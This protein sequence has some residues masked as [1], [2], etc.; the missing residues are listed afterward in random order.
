MTARLVT[1]PTRTGNGPPGRLRASLLAFLAL[2]A[3]YPTQTLAGLLAGLPDAFAEVGSGRP[4]TPARIVGELESVGLVRVVDWPVVE[5]LADWDPPTDGA[6]VSDPLRRYCE[7]LM[8]LAR[9]DREDQAAAERQ[10][11]RVTRGR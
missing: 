6:V 9:L 10:G 5:V 8:A 4:L 11:Q 2:D 1:V 7:V 3:P